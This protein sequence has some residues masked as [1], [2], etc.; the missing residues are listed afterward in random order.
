[1]EEKE[2]LLWYS[3]W[4]TLNT[5]YIRG[6]FILYVSP[7][8]FPVFLMPFFCVQHI[9][10]HFFDPC[11][12]TPHPSM[13]RS[14]Y[15]VDPL[16]MWEPCSDSSRQP[17][18]LC[19]ATALKSCNKPATSAVHLHLRSEAASLWS[20][21]AELTSSVTLSLSFWLLCFSFPFFFSL[22]TSRDRQSDADTHNKEL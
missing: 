13:Q 7:V 16:C 14:H 15:S 18:R 5:F 17:G 2:D 11:T 19:D 6:H 10:L 8:P 20:P 12:F 3:L 4:P 1:M 22:Y 21:A 9:D